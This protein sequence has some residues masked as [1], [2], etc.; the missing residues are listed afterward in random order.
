MIS[1]VTWKWGTAFTAAHVNNLHHALQRHLRV[2]HSFTCITDDW[3]GIEDGIALLAM[4]T[5]HG[6]MRN[7]NRA[8]F[9][10]LWMLSREAGELLGNPEAMPTVGARILHLDLDVVL[11][12]D[13]TPLFDRPE[14]LVI[15]DQQRPGQRPVYNPSMMLFDAGVLAGAWDK[16]HADPAGTLVKAVAAG[17][18]QS[19]MAIVNFFAR[20][21][22]PPT[23]GDADGVHA[24]H[25]LKK[26]GGEL[27][28]G[29][30]AVVFHGPDDPSG[31]MAQKLAWVREHWR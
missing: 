15:Y 18:T 30:R 8:C 1:V 3:T 7:G 4:R 11:V 21:M 14:P 10:R 16:F 26:S 2:P 6:E 5:D 27:P 17:C 22:L 9:R 29:A 25:R 12:D 24:W 31:A 19:D 23:W 20:P 13:V 28:A